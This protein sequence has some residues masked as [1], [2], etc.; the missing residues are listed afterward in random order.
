METS[1]WVIPVKAGA[2]KAAK[3]AATSRAAFS[4]IG[5]YDYTDR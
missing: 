4:I 3:F 2:S 1:K 5:H